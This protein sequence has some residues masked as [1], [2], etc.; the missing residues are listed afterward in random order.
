MNQ[1]IR[2]PAESLFVRQNS[3][4]Q[5]GPAG[6]RPRTGCETP[7][8]ICIR[9][10]ANRCTPH[11]SRQHHSPRPVHID[12]QLPSTDTPRRIASR[13][14]MARKMPTIA[15][16]TVPTP[17]PTTPPVPA[18]PAPSS[19]TG[20][21]GT[22]V[23]PPSTVSQDNVPQAPASVTTG[24]S[25]WDAGEDGRPAEECMLVILSC[26]PIAI[27]SVVYLLHIRLVRL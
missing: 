17:P 8:G 4:S 3:G 22:V 15:E 25:G 23:N 14:R 19:S 11:L 21:S 27:V 6:P 16:D 18:Q 9:G 1:A 26:V 20:G 2:N 12:P 13:A 10:Y 24:L 5:N 7:S